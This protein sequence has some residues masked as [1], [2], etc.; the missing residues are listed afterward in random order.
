M[1]YVLEPE[2]SLAKE[3]SRVVRKELDDAVSG[4]DS[5]AGAR[6]AVHEAR[7]SIKKVRAVLRLLRKDLGHDFKKRNRQLRK[8]SRALSGLRDGDVLA[9]TVGALR[10]SDPSSMASQAEREILRGLHAAGRNVRRD[11]QKNT[12][13]ALKILRQA[14]KSLPK[15]IRDAGRGDAPRGGVV[16]GYKKA[17]RAMRDLSA[18]ASADD[19]HAW[20]RRTKD[21]WYHMRLLKQRTRAAAVRVSELKRLETWL[22]DANDLELL[23][24]AILKTPQGSGDDGSRAVALRAL[25]K[26]QDVLRRRSLALGRRLFRATPKQFER[27]AKWG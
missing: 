23:R 17:R 5:S 22:G 19:F 24:A 12:R 7:K 8:A 16:E 9:G 26:A 3:L 2:R 6:T 20:R 15:E 14:G 13:R 10:K 27:S 1:A 25:D 21:H 18:D 11:A 4:L